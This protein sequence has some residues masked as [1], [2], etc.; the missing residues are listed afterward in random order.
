ML[1]KTLLRH[2]R[3]SR[4]L[5]LDAVALHTG[6]DDSTLSRIERGLIQPTEPQRHALAGF[7]GRPIDELLGPAPEIAA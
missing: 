1:K 6:I 2:I 4:D 5:T 7:Y 3:R